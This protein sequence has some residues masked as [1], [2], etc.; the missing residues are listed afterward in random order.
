MNADE[1]EDWHDN[2]PRRAISP[3]AWVVDPKDLLKL[4]DD[5]QARTRA[6]TLQWV[7]DQAYEG[8]FGGGYV[9]EI[10][11]PSVIRTALAHNS[12]EEDSHGT[13]E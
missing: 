9:M 13:V 11:E 1:L 12:Q 7:L 2:L 4:I 10:I 8:D 5:A 3:G 6:E